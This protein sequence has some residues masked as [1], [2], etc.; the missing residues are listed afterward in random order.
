MPTLNLAVKGFFFLCVC[1]TDPLPKNVLKLQQCQ[2]EKISHPKLIEKNLSG[3]GDMYSYVYVYIFLH[4]P[5]IKIHFNYPN[6]VNIALQQAFGKS[7]FTQVSSKRSS[8]LLPHQRWTHR[9]L[10]LCSDTWIQKYYSGLT[11]FKVFERAALMQTQKHNEN[12][13]RSS[14]LLHNRT[15]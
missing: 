9:K 11:C 3:V 8:F 7:P 14:D 5:L 10:P 12:T 6:H 15:R 4:W 13:N 1:L 2:A